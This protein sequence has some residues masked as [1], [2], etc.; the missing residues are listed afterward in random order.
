[1]A[2]VSHCG[3]TRAGLI[4][5]VDSCRRGKDGRGIDSD[6]AYMRTRRRTGRESEGDG[7]AVGRRKWKSGSNNIWHENNAFGTSRLREYAA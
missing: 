1:M 3:E 4:G 6:T 7:D 2:D 5:S